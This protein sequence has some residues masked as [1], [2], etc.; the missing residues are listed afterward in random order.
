MIP[1]SAQATLTLAAIAFACWGTWAVAFK[2]AGSK[3]RF[4]HFYFDFAFGALAASLIAGFTLGSS[5]RDLTLADAFLISSRKQWALAAAAGAV[6]NL[7]N[8]LLLAAVEIRGMTIAFPLAMATAATVTALRILVTSRGDNPALLVAGAALLAASIVLAAMAAGRLSATPAAG[9]GNQKS[10]RKEGSAKPVTL[11]ILGGLLF[12]F[13]EFP[14]RSA[15]QGV[16][17]L[18]M[19]PYALAL[20][21]CLGILITTVIYNLYFLNLPVHGEPAGF[22][23]YFQGRI[24]THLLGVL[25]GVIFAGGL[26]GAFVVA[27]AEGDAA[28]AGGVNAVLVLASAILAALWGLLAFGEF[29][30][31]RQGGF[32]L[33][34]L[35]LIS[36][37]GGLAAVAIRIGI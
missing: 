18:S 5:G 21:F 7:G 13:S 36:L 16:G 6:F 26:L 33:A 15:R 35:A 4:E 12:A 31:S 3:W 29:R 8:M 9:A 32:V 19:G 14:L 10:I 25:G 27:E 30:Q 28:L 37:A 24:G 11:A 1:N 17:D 20:L 34:V 22:G 23:P 2:M